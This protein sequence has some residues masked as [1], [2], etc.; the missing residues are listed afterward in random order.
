MKIFRADLHIHTVLSPCGDLDMSPVNIVNEAAKK[1]L[2]I[3]GITD[4]N[5]TRHCNLISRLAAEKGIFVMQGAEITTKE[6]VHCLA[7]FENTD[8]L[9][10]FQEFLDANLPDIL[11]NPEKFGYQ[12]QV[13][14]NDIVIFE[15]KRLLINAISKSFEEV[16]AFVHSLKGI[17]I[18]AH[19]DRMKNSIYSQL[20][21]LP[22]NMKADALE[23]SAL[24]TPAKF[25]AIH[26]EVKEFS[27]TRSS[28][29]HFPDYIGKVFTD[30]SIEKRSFSEIKMA[31]K[32]T[33]GRKIITE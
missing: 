19:I 9:N 32:G 29:A 17:F 18:P 27:L 2:D 12:V 7:F 28:D 16:E 24:S 30:F 4:H 15:E 33:D 20:G 8:A 13:D 5:S 21:F 14:E 22:E 26:P 3:I 23:I 31:L 1:G 6:E 11:N 10:L 25:A